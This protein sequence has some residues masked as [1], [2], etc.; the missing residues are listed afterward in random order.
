[1]SYK[2]L[3]KCLLTITV[4]LCAQMSAWALGIG[5]GS[6][7]PTPED[8]IL[9]WNRILMETILTP[10]Q[11]PPTIMPVRSYAIMHAAMFDAVKMK[12]PSPFNHHTQLSAFTI[13]CR[14]HNEDDLRW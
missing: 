1:M 13:D 4:L 14:F 10:G 5:A 11:H 9:R 2:Q 6:L 7:P 8:V 3:I 12:R